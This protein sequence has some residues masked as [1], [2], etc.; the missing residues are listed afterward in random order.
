MATRPAASASAFFGTPDYGW[1]TPWQ[2][3]EGAAAAA[4][5]GPDPVTGFRLIFTLE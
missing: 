1:R 3:L 4:E 2:R 5:A